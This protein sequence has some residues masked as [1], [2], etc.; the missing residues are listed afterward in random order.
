MSFVGKLKNGY[1]LTGVGCRS[2]GSLFPTKQCAVGFYVDAFSTAAHLLAI[3]HSFLNMALH[4]LRDNPLFYDGL[5]R[6]DYKCCLLMSFV[7]S[8]APGEVADMFRNELAQLGVPQTALEPFLKVLSTPLRASQRVL[9][10]LD[11]ASAVKLETDRPPGSSAA[12][13]ATTIESRELSRAIR[14]YLFSSS[15]CFSPSARAGFVERF[16][17]IFMYVERKANQGRAPPQVSESSIPANQPNA[18]EQLLAQKHPGLVIGAHTNASHNNSSSNTPSP[19]PTAEQHDVS[20]RKHTPSQSRPRAYSS[21]SSASPPSSAKQKHTLLPSNSTTSSTTATDN[22]ALA[23]TTSGLQAHENSTLR[24]PSQTESISRS[25]RPGTPTSGVRIPTTAGATAPVQ[26]ITAYPRISL[27]ESEAI[28]SLSVAASSAYGRKLGLDPNSFDF[29]TN[30]DNYPL[31]RASSGATLPQSRSGSPK[32]TAMTPGRPFGAVAPTSSNPNVASSHRFMSTSFGTAEVASSAGDGFLLGKD[33][34]SREVSLSHEIAQSRTH[35]RSRGN[36]NDSSFASGPGFPVGTDSN[37]SGSRLPV[38]AQSY[39]D[40]MVSA[41]SAS[42]APRFGSAHRPSLAPAASI[43]SRPVA[44]FVK[45]GYLMRYAASIF[46]DK[47]RPRF[48]QLSGALLIYRLSPKEDIRGCVD[49]SRCSLAIESKRRKVGPN[50]QLPGQ[51][52][53]VS[54]HVVFSVTEVQTGVVFRLSTDADSA[55][56]W[57]R[58]LHITIL[59][60]KQEAAALSTLGPAQAISTPLHPHG[61]QANAAYQQSAD[62]IAS[63]TSPQPPQSPQVQGAQQSPQSPAQQPSLSSPSLQSPLPQPPSPQAQV[64]VQSQHTA[65][66]MSERKEGP[67][68]LYPSVVSGAMSPSKVPGWGAPSPHSPDRAQPPPARAKEHIE[69]RLPLERSVRDTIIAIFVII[70]QLLVLYTVVVPSKTDSAS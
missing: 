49:L 24:V 65:V 19:T 32:L 20:H 2:A 70:L 12:P 18:A 8:M 54:E 37:I 50:E 59:A 39:D 11:G 31:N 14:T 51:T 38:S 56:L 40:S 34:S 33:G 61:E 67:H 28:A 43:L 15:I 5:M 68:P 26:A 69:T 29:S 55:R 23:T 41:G 16:P 66:A 1:I 45:T 7:K 22:C 17:N 53:P 52:V 10:M 42:A 46:G 3:S 63:L 35:S 13:H 6:G 60:A 30:T 25:S 48:F 27:A 64:Q 9:I 21:L 57:I 58:A 4:Q 36:D 44:L 62:V 47:W